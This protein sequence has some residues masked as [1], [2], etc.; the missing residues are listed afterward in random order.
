MFKKDVKK[1]SEAIAR[2]FYN[3]TNVAE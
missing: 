1:A 2:F 3:N